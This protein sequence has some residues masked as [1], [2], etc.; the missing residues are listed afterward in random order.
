MV[1]FDTFLGGINQGLLWAIMAIGVYISYRI[2]D[3]AD[4]TVEGSFATGG[5][6]AA[7]IMTL[8]KSFVSKGA[9]EGI[10]MSIVAL[11][12]AMLL[13]GLAGLVTGILN[14]K[15]KIAPILSGILTM[16]GLYSINMVI[17]GIG[18]GNI[19]ANL[20][21]GSTGTIFTK[22]EEFMPIGRNWIIFI[23]GILAIAAVIGMI[24]WF[25]GTETGSAM[26]ATGNNEKMAKAQGINTQASKILGLV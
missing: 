8:S 17:M 1:I 4:L 25:F 20:G 24:Y 22:I 2:L 10:L 16:T 13:G 11:I 12:V 19:K 5:A 7:I 14:T 3:F 23:V 6:T 21:I 15:F 9:G 18:S 26:R